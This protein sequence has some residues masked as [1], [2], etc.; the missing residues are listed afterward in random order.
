MSQTLDVSIEV[1]GS[2]PGTGYLTLDE[3]ARILGVTKGKAMDFLIFQQ[4][5][6]PL[7]FERKPYYEINA[8]RLKQL[9][10]QDVPVQEDLPIR[11]AGFSGVQFEQTEI[12]ISVQH[13][14][15]LQDLVKVKR[16]ADPL[17]SVPQPSLEN[18]PA[19][20]GYDGE[21]LS[22]VI[23]VYVMELEQ[24]FIRAEALAFHLG[25]LILPFYLADQNIGGKT[26]FRRAS[27]NIL[28]DAKAEISLRIYL[29]SK[30][31]VTYT[32]PFEFTG[33]RGIYKF[34]NDEFFRGCFGSYG[35]GATVVEELLKTKR[36]ELIT[37]L[38]LVLE[39]KLE[40][41]Y[42]RLAHR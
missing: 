18:T 31:P 42:G 9:A 27:K 14:G 8:A 5:I 20:A 37:S 4:E 15:T 30:R 23:E 38:H 19:R 32:E 41:V 1:A 13:K 3:I 10:N 6:R 39:K 29:R 33:E 16:R 12:G 26:N 22:K 34:A 35:V 36:P 25:Y 17:T 21:S 40:E 11:E 24:E 7:I 28:R 2:K